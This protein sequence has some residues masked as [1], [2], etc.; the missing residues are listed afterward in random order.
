VADVPSGLSLDSTH[1]YANFKKK[2]KDC[3]QESVDLI[4]GRDK[5]FFSSPQRPV[6]FLAHRAS[7]PIV[8]RVSFLGGKAAGT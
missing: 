8:T 1:H 3:I 2:A 4:P 7:Y 5:I 6:G